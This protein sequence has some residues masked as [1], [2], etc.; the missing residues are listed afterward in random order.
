MYREKFLVEPMLGRLAKWLRIWGYDAEYLPRSDKKNIT[1]KSL[2]QRRIVLTRDHMLSKKKAWRLILVKDDRFE[3]QLKQ[4]VKE[5]NLKPDPDKLFS[6]CTLCNV[7][8]EKIEKVRVKGKVP[9]YIYSIHNDFSYCP[10]C[11]RIYWP[12]SHIQLLENKLKE[13]LKYKWK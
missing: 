12:G 9:P 7:A 10:E 8:V 3:K 2:Q 1:Y 11:K 4:L 13:I 6:R 5:L